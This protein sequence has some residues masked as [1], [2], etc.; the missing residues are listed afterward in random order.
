M[1]ISILILTF[2]E[3]LNISKC[4]DSISDFDDIVVLDS[5]STDSTVS[6]AESKGAR[7]FKKKFNNFADQR[8]YA[9]KNFEFKNEWVLHLDADEILTPELEKEIKNLNS[10][11]SFDAFKIASKMFFLGKWLRYSSM[12]PVYQVRL[13]RYKKLKFKQY[14][15]GQIEDMDAK[16]VGVLKEAYIHNTFSK[17][18]DE[19]FNKHNKYSS[20]EADLDLKIKKN[21]FFFELMNFVSIKNTDRRRAL[22]TLSVFL[23][24]RSFL[25]FLYMYILKFGFLD[26]YPGFL[27][28][29]LLS[30][31]EN[32]IDIKTEIN[33]IDDINISK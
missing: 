5:Y 20:D 31:Y 16:T 4:I 1:K 29:R 13:G 9:L 7:V 11:V 18:I 10:N 33:K 23:P 27:Y 6:I 32:M 26:G 24:F 30:I 19:W 14:G 21:K 17:G 8:N 28:C 22:K 12:Y 2:N 25:R 3:E 15:H